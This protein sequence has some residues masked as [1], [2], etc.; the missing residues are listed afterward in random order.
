M[1]PED[2]FAAIVYCHARVECFVVENSK[3]P[4]RYGRLP[5]W[6]AKIAFRISA[7]RLKSAGL[8]GY[9]DPLFY[10]LPKSA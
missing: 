10:S 7:G 9:V 2:S 8:T 4:G 1:T 3:P 5:V 6:K